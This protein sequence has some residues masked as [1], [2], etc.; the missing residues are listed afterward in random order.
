MENIY[1]VAGN[2]QFAVDHWA[3]QKTQEISNQISR[4]ETEM[5][6][7]LSRSILNSF[8]V[9]FI[10]IMQAEFSISPEIISAPHYKRYNLSPV[11]HLPCLSSPTQSLPTLKRII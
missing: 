10:I 7:H 1:K 4:L 11:P 9:V 3:Q 6:F 5:E 8:F 2:E